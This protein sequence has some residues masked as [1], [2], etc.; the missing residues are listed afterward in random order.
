LQITHADR[1]NLLAAVMVLLEFRT[2]RVLHHCAGKNPSN[3][4]ANHI[5]NGPSPRH[6]Y[7]KQVDGKSI[8]LISV[9]AVVP[10][11]TVNTEKPPVR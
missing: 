5:K 7:L 1:E 4:P 8:Y 11:V 3:E 9:T 2:F 10:K 6:D